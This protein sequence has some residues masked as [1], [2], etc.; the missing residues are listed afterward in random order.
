M[1]KYFLIWKNKY[2]T[3]AESVDITA[4]VYKLLYLNPDFIRDF[5]DKQSDKKMVFKT[6]LKAF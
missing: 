3:S 1:Y 6:P 2:K 5:A 4:T